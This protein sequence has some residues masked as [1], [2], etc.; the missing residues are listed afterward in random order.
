MDGLRR[1]RSV[2]EKSVRT[3]R[4]VVLPPGFYDDLRLVERVEELDV[5]AFISELSIEALIVS[6]LPRAS[7]LDEEGPGAN[8]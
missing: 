3:N 6:V 7:R 8:H 1:W 2:P 4:I 5:E